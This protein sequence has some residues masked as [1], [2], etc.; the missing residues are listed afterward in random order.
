M[1]RV[2]RFSDIGL[3]EIIACN[4]ICKS[5][6]KHKVITPRIYAEASVRTLFTITQEFLRNLF[7]NIYIYRERKTNII[8]DFNAV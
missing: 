5:I 1:S 6:Q 7:F 8:L 2:T 3:Y 4:C